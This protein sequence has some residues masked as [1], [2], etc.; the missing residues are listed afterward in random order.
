MGY[1]SIKDDREYTVQI[2][3]FRGVVSADII[4]RRKCYT[5]DRLPGL[6]LTIMTKGFGSWWRSAPR[7]SDWLRAKKWAEQQLDLIERHGTV[8]VTT[9]Q[10]LIDLKDKK[11]SK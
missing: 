7:E 6:Y 11:E 3:P 8:T 1:K 4:S 9:P 2:T 5:D 10:W